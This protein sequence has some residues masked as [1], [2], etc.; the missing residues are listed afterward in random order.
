MIMSCLILNQDLVDVDIPER[1]RR[2]FKVQSVYER[3]RYCMFSFCGFQNIQF[4]KPTVFY[5]C[6]IL[7][8]FCGVI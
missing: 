7:I 8:L 2:D 3:G 4:T 1:N 6:I 5:I